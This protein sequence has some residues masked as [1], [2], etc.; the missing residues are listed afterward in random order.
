MGESNT[1]KRAENEREMRDA[2][3][4]E[5]NSERDVRKSTRG[6]C[7]PFPKRLSFLPLRYSY[8]NFLDLELEMS[9]FTHLELQIDI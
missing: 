3:G 7:L 4:G 8:C 2:G 6:L 5:R 1:T 9:T